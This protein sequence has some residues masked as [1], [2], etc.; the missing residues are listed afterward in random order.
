M[1]SA[2]LAAARICYWLVVVPTTVIAAWLAVRSVF[3]LF[4]NIA[5]LTVGLAA[6]AFLILGGG[7]LARRSRGRPLL[8]RPLN[9]VEWIFVFVMFWTGAFGHFLAWNVCLALYQYRYVYPEREVEG[10]PL[11]F[12]CVVAATS[13]LATLLMGEFGIRHDK[14]EGQP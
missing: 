1:K 6:M 5:V 12:F 4:S 3:A 13:Y 2:Y 11:A 8:P 14:R 7:A 10:G 9:H